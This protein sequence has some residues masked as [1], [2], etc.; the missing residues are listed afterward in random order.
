MPMH[1]VKK[2][3]FRV[4]VNYA[5][6]VPSKPFLLAEK[7]A[8]KGVYLWDQDPTASRWQGEI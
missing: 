7:K 6:Y 5:F 2:Q 4:R 3:I 8:F 1:T